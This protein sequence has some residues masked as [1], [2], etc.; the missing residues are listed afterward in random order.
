MAQRAGAVPI[1]PN[2]GR[3]KG[4]VFGFTFGTGHNTPQR[5]QEYQG[6][7]ANKITGKD[8]FNGK[9]VRLTTET[10]RLIGGFLSEIQYPR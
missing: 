10:A 8:N 4:K 2:L 6:R 1:K 7:K 5:Q 3:N 9:V